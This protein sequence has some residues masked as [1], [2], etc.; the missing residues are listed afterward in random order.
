MYSLMKKWE[1]LQLT[2]NNWKS[3]E[4]GDDYL[5]NTQIYSRQREFE[6][7]NMIFYRFFSEST[8]EIV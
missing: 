8:N 4:G 3:E 5:D 6:F 7:L 1:Q 2:L